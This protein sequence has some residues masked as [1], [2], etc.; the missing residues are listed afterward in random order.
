MIIML[1]VTTR[2]KW[3]AGFSLQVWQEN[4]LKPLLQVLI[5][6]LLLSALA[7][8]LLLSCF[9]YWPGAIPEISRK[10]V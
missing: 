6:Q 5:D 9:R 3:S 8:I 2:R 7:Y 10:A 1:F 4:R